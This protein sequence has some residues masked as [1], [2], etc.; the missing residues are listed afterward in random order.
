VA[1]AWQDSHL[2][3][4]VVVVLIAVG[5]PDGCIMTFNGLALIAHGALSYD[6]V[7]T[8]VI[9]VS[10]AP[11]PG[12]DMIAAA[13]GTKQAYDSFGQFTMAIDQLRSGELPGCEWTIPPPPNNQ[14]FVPDKVNFEYTP[15]ANAMPQSLP[16]AIDLAG[17]KGG[18]G[19][20]YDSNTTPTKI[21]LCPLSCQT[22]PNHS[23]WDVLFGC[24]SQWN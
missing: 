15:T 23:A 18:D 21:I 17:C 3:D 24:P 4:K 12:L 8:Y 16:R 10:G 1:T 14:P 2:M 11:N 22:V 13:G 19:W 20:F 7:R 5:D 6:G 9:N